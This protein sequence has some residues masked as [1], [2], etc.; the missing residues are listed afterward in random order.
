MDVQEL[1]VRAVPEGVSDT[2]DGL[3]EMTD[4]VEDSTDQMDEQA[5]S[6]ADLSKQFAGAMNVAVAGLAVA[7]ASLL[8]QVPVLGEAFDGLFAIVSGV[9]FQMDSVLRPVLS[10]LTDAFLNVADTIF[11]AE[12]AGGALVGMLGTLVTIFGAVVVPAAALAA[13]LGL[14]AST[15]AAL[16][17]AGSTLIGVI[18]AIAGAIVSL[19]GLIAVGIAA[20]VGFIAA[21]LTNWNGARDKTN[22]IVGEIV[23]LVKEGFSTFVDKAKEFL[24]K[25]INALK[26]GFPGAVKAVSDFVSD[27][28]DKFTNIISNAKNWGED[29][30]GAFI[31]GVESKVSTLKSKV[32][33]VAGIISDHLPSSDA[34]TGP[35]S[36]LTSQG[37][38]L[39][40]AFVGGASGESNDLPGFLRG[41]LEKATSVF[42]TLGS[43]ARAFSG[44]F[45]GIIN[46]I[47]TKIPTPELNLSS[48][49]QTVSGFVSTINGFTRELA[50]M[51]TRLA[52][53]I[54]KSVNQSISDMERLDTTMSENITTERTLTT[55]A[56]G[57]S[58]DDS[59]DFIGS[60][61]SGRGTINLDGRDVENTQGRYRADNLHRRG[62]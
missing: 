43:E 26:N 46:N 19:P 22:A 15:G 13:K 32:S 40:S 33:D 27:V 55:Q 34:D 5:S 2:V 3:G 24:G 58:S 28:G 1:V 30:I 38:G 35:L 7:S 25:L 48:A 36:N 62:G 59:T 61:G 53:I 31:D 16:I 11:Q 50:D 29:L 4:Q 51:F 9:A 6:M 39:I 14:A 17:S 8:S 49:L 57:N 54:R 12:G 20:L 37:A 18:A 21:Y 47:Q 60:V 56:N 52:A 42:K 23:K 44:R 45:R 10:P 41:T